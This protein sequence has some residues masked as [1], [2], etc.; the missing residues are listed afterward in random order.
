MTSTIL[1]PQEIQTYQGDLL[2]LLGIAWVLYYYNQQRLL[3][4]E[5]L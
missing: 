4:V 5:K 2:F 3:E 1:D